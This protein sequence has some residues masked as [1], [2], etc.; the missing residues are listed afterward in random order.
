MLAAGNPHVH[1]R[2]AV[3]PARQVAAALCVWLYT[4]VL[5]VTRCSGHL[6]CDSSGC[7]LTAGMLGSVEAG[8]VLVVVVLPPNP[9]PMHCGFEPRTLLPLIL[10]QWCRGWSFVKVD[11]WQGGELLW[12]R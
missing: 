1:H 11:G 7:M 12:G 3:G 6:W 8:V 5:A 4:S 10:Q 9:T 2:L